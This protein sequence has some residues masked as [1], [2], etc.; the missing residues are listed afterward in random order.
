MDAT[1]CN[2]WQFS[3]LF[4]CFQLRLN[5][6]QWNKRNRAKVSPAIT[7]ASL[8]AFSVPCIFVVWSS[9]R[10]TA[11]HQMFKMRKRNYRALH[12]FPDRVSLT[13]KQ[14]KIP[15]RLTKWKKKFNS[16]GKKYKLQKTWEIYRRVWNSLSS[17]GFSFISRDMTLGLRN[18]NAYK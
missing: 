10:H 13:Q 7:R 9:Q 12:A 5:W 14:T 18:Q 6:E 3:L 15:S 11:N 16:K 2:I 8:C 4:G 1:R 17:H